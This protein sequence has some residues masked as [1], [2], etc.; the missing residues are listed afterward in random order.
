MLL[1]TV[2]DRIARESEW[3]CRVT[4][5]TSNRMTCLIVEE[6]EEAN[7]SALFETL[8]AKA[9]SVVKGKEERKQ[10]LQQVNDFTRETF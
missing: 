6:M 2:H 7:A 4:R 1:H 5:F 3:T 9:V 8:S 10:K